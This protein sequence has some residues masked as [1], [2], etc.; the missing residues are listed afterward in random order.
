M[1]TAPSMVDTTSGRAQVSTAEVEERIREFF[2]EN[3][4]ALRLEGDRTLAPEVKEAALQQVL[5]YWRR[6]QDIALKVTDTEVRLNLP[7]QTTARG[8]TYGIEG[9]VDIVREQDST[10]MYDVKTHDADAIRGNLAEYERQLNVYAY[11]WQKLRGEELD[12]MAIICTRF[13]PAIKEALEEGDEARAERELPKWNPVIDVEFDEGHV[14]K[15]IADF[16]QV[17]DL[18]EDGAFAP[19]PV[20]K[21]R[22]IRPGERSPFAVTVC[23]NCDAR[24]SCSSYRT[25]AL[26][27]GGAAERRFREYFADV[28]D[29]TARDSWLSA[30]LAAAP[31]ADAFADVATLQEED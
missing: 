6:L 1:S 3:F 17:V 31:P 5:L 20:D 10:V 8:R 26:G 30:T 7:H 4:E 28:G 15:T 18:I 23:R 2:D 21:L 27:A 19:S 16:G 25:H 9:V 29:D 12:A 22:V 11:I 13:P 14:R 24:F